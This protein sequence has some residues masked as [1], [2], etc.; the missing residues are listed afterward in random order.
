VVI[1][2]CS[3]RLIEKRKMVSTP[4]PRLK[5]GIKNLTKSKGSIVEGIATRRA[6]I[7]VEVALT[8]SY[9]KPVCDE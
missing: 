8:V 6:I 9:A 3:A 7:A 1:S 4:S 2:F 5:F